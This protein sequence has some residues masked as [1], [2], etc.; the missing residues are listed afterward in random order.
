MSQGLTGFV[1]NTTGGLSRLYCVKCRDETIHRRGICLCGT[2]HEA[3]PV[4]DLASK[5]V[6]QGLTI[7]RRK[8]NGARRK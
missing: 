6:A 3:Y 8:W 1:T 5:W 2:R 7:Q 4:R